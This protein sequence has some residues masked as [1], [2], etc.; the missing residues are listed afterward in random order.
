MRFIRLLL[1]STLLLILG[2]SGIIWYINT[3]EG[4]YNY[5]YNREYIYPYNGAVCP[6]C[7]KELRWF[8]T[9]SLGNRGYCCDV[10]QYY[11]IH[12]DRL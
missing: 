3:N 12:L 6:I 2:I 8:N 1:I 5:P 7:G 4:E 10:C 11:Y 9:V